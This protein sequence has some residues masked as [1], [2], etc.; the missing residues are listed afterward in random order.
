MHSAY[1]QFAVKIGRCCAIHGGPNS[2]LI[3]TC[4]S[5]CIHHP[6]CSTESPMALQQCVDIMAS[7]TPCNT[8][9]ILYQLDNKATILDNCHELG[10]LVLDDKVRGESSTCLLLLGI[11][12]DTVH[13]VMRLSARRESSNGVSTIHH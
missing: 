12:M 9:T 2:I 7:R 8:S 11:E 13:L 10:A 5:A 4:L 1:A 6:L 3:C